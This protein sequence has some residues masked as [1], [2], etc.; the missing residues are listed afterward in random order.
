[1]S[2]GSC[3]CCAIIFCLTSSENITFVLVFVASVPSV[4]LLPPEAIVCHSGCATRGGC[5]GIGA[6]VGKLIPAGPLVLK[7]GNA[8][9]G[10]WA[11]MGAGP[12]VIPV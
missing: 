3:L 9:G 7:F 5:S 4:Q 1:M 8:T 2:A 10:G 12:A 11:K 6:G